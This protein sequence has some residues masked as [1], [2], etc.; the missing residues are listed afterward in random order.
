MKDIDKNIIDKASRC[1]NCKVPRCKSACP[2]SQDIPTMMQLVKN[3]EGEKAYRHISNINLLGGICGLVCPHEQQCQ[4][5]CVLG[6]KGEPVAIGDVESY[7]HQNFGSSFEVESNS[8]KGK[9]VAVVGA[10]PAGLACSWQI[11]KHGGQAVVFER[12]EFLGGVPRYGIPPFRCERVLPENVVDALKQ[13]GVDF[14]TNVLVGRDFKLADLA[15]EYDAVFVGV[16]LNKDYTLDIEGEDLSGVLSGNDYLKAPQL[17]ENTIVIGGG[18]VAMDCART[19]ARLGSKTKI[20]YRRGYKEMPAWDIEKEHTLR[21]GVEFQYLL[22]PHRVVGEK[23]VEAVEFI[24]NTLGEIDSSGRASVVATE[25]IMTFPCDLLLVGTGSYFDKSIFE[26][27]EIEFEK[28]KVKV[29]EKMKASKNIFAGGDIVN[30][31]NTVVQ[32]VVDGKTA[33][34]AIVEFLNK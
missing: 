1:L 12:T 15:K 27:T 23:K 25:E 13:N 29:D 22:S 6:I 32:A 8:L 24:V 17:A 3:N 16:G 21:D 4:G 20:C 30:K 31:Q 14:R 7:V 33:G 9:E 34:Q 5:S 28:N 2:I 26:D 19:S 18:N 10:G 11:A